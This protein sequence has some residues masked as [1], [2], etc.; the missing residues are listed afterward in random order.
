M[1]STELNDEHWMGLALA[2]ARQAAVEGE[3]PVGAVA[4]SRGVP[5]ARNHNRSIQLNDPTAH[6]E[7]LVLRQ[8]GNRLG[9]YRLSGLE[10]YVTVEPC[11]MCAGALIWARVSR[12]VYG[13]ADPKGGGVESRFRILDPGR[14]NHEVAVQPGVLADPCLRLMQEF[15]A[16]KRGTPGPKTDL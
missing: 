16:H 12:L 7:I 1:S 2:E 9:N 5:V 10:L 3:V 13:T 11:P 6:A 4:V 15:F 14:L 8:A